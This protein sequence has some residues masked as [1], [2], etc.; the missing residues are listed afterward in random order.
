M[1]SIRHDLLA[2]EDAS[3]DELS[4]LM[5]ADTKLCCGIA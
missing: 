2:L 1:G 3:L 4:N 5:M